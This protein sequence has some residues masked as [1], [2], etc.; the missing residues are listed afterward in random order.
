MISVHNRNDILQNGGDI[1]HNV[2]WMWV[3]FLPL[4]RRWSVDALVA[5]FRTPDPDDAALNRTR[6]RDTRPYTTITALAIIL[7]LSLCYFL[8]GFHKNGQT[9]LSGDAVALTLE[10]DRIVTTFG[11]LIREYA[12]LWALKLLTWGTLFIE[13]A[14]PLFLLTPVFSLWARRFILLALAGFHVG[15]GLALQLGFFSFW[16]VSLYFLLIRPED[17][18]HLS[19]WFKPRSKPLTVFYDSDCGV[20]HL[21]ARLCTRLDTYRLVTWVGRGEISHYPAGLNEAEFYA[22]RENTLI[23]SPS[24]QLDRYATHHRSVAEVLKRL[25]F[26]TP[27]A[28]LVILTGPVGQYAYQAF[29][30][31]R[32]SVSAWLGYGVCGLQPP[33]S[34]TQSTQKDGD[35]H[36]SQPV[37]TEA[38]EIKPK[39]G[40][41]R[42]QY[43]VLRG[44][45]ELYIVLAIFAATVTA[46]HSNR[47]FKKRWKPDYPRWARSF[48]TYGRFYQNWRLF[49][50]EAPYDDGWMILETRLKDGRVLDMRTGLPPDYQVPNYRNRSWG[51]YEA[52]WGFRLKREKNLWP[53]F[54]NWAKRPVRHLRLGPK[55]RIEEI[56]FYWVSDKTQ[57]VVAGGPRPPIP[58]GK[59]L[60][61]SWSRR[62]EAALKKK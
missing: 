12:P 15:A 34:G 41:V 23:S 46:F 45:V 16:M 30:A 7:N 11:G 20:C 56:N 40:W 36:S 18:V 37:Y 43:K 58:K 55:D 32:Q 57:P 5:S 59:K 26:L 10:Q 4:G 19:R 35:D 22:L 8:N 1:V 48:V 52:R 60:I 6:R 39:S 51:F 14:A 9:W 24:D 61:R 42:L 62:S 31:R 28:W 49:S 17:W 21:F 47:F 3:I 2:W 29:A 38:W 25:P 27:L 50:P 54:I 44:S 13:G 53:L 33:S